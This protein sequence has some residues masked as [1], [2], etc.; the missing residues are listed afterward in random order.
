[1]QKGFAQPLL[2]IAFIAF[3]GLSG[4]LWLLNSD[5]LSNDNVKGTSTDVQAS[6]KPGLVVDVTCSG[7]TWELIQYLCKTEEE[8]NSS[9]T[10]GKRIGSIGGGEADSQKIT[11]PTAPN[12]NEYK[13]IKVFVKHGWNSRVTGFEVSNL[14][15][16]GGIFAQKFG[17][18]SAVIVPMELVL[19]NSQDVAS[20]SDK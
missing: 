10:S 11:I 18:D 14:N 13:Y 6:E 4:A 16:S 12:W 2:V 8:C 3:V 20:F 1:M 5:F 19:N 7:G 17:E 9:L 15:N